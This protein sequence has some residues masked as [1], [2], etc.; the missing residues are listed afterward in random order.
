M[1][2]RSFLVRGAAALCVVGSCFA[3]QAQQ[4]ANDKTIL[5][6]QIRIAQT[7]LMVAGLSCKQ[8]DQYAPV[9]NTKRYNEFVTRYQPILMNDGHRVLKRFFPT[10]QRLNDYLT[11]LA[12]EAQL[13]G[14]A[15]MAIFCTQ[16]AKIY[17]DVLNHGAVEL[18]SYSASLPMSSRHGHTPC[19]AAPAAAPAAA[20]IPP[21]AA[22]AP[23]VQATPAVQTAPAELPPV[24]SPVVP[25]DGPAKAPEASAPVKTQTIAAV[26]AANDDPSFGTMQPVPDMSMQPAVKGSPRIVLKPSGI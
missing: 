23:V 16:A 3:A 12:N 19:N 24:R 15:N 11:R 6:M 5:A 26:I 7:E 8:Y 1:K 13:R 18:A 25:D 17:D 14:N 22:A 21:A 4:C 10:E 20:T 9:A 2:F